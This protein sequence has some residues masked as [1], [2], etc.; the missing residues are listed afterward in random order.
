MIS[1]IPMSRS[2]DTPAETG[3]IKRVLT[4]ISCIS[5]R[6]NITLDHERGPFGG[7]ILRVLTQDMYSAAVGLHDLR[8]TADHEG[9]VVRRIP[10]R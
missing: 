10:P 3:G 2:L 1:H 8:I 9:E 6:M 5:D 7:L 4:F